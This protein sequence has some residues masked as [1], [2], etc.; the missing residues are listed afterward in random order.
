MSFGIFIIL[1]RSIPSL[2]TPDMAHTSSTLG[3]AFTLARET[4][5]QYK[6]A[7]QLLTSAM[8]VDSSPGVS[9]VLLDS[10]RHHKIVFAKDYKPLS[11]NE[12]LYTAFSALLYTVCS[13]FQVDET[14]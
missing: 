14:R 12:S 1:G 4:S 8:H 7:G 6:A 3:D 11:Q 9:K 13:K 5:S 2:T 10:K